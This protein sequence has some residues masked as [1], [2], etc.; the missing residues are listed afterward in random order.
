MHLMKRISLFTILI[1]SRK[2]C[3]LGI[4]SVSLLLFGT[5]NFFLRFEHKFRNIRCV[6]VISHFIYL[7]FNF[8]T[9]ETRF[10]DKAER[11]KKLIAS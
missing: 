2:K 5:S 1:I 9:N 6:I 3:S 4:L 8:K 11:E 7:F 10:F